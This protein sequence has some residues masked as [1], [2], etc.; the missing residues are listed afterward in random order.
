MQA[1]R[2]ESPKRVNDVRHW[3]KPPTGIVPSRSTT[4]NSE[5]LENEFVKVVEIGIE[6][7]K[8]ETKISEHMINTLTQDP[9]KG[10]SEKDAETYPS[11]PPL[12]E[13]VASSKNENSNTSEAKIID[14]LYPP[15]PPID[16]S[17]PPIVPSAPPMH[18]ELNEQ[19]LQEAIPVAT[20][21]EQQ[22][23]N[24]DVTSPASQ[25]SNIGGGRRAADSYFKQSITSIPIKR[26]ALGNFK[27]QRALLKIN[28]I[29]KNDK[30]A[31]IISF[32]K[33]DSA[34]SAVTFLPKQRNESDKNDLISILSKPT[35]ESLLHFDDQSLNLISQL[36][37][38]L[39]L[40]SDDLLISIIKRFFS[41]NRSDLFENVIE[42]VSDGSQK[43]NELDKKIKLRELLEQCRMNG[44]FSFEKF[45]EMNSLNEDERSRSSLIELVLHQHK[46]FN[47]PI[48]FN[49]ETVPS[50]LNQAI[51]KKWFE[52]MALLLNEDNV[53]N[54]IFYDGWRDSINAKFGQ[55][56]LCTIIENENLQ[57][58]LY[59]VG[60]VAQF[61]TESSFFS[62][63][64]LCKEIMSKCIEKNSIQINE[65]LEPYLKQLDQCKIRPAF[66]VRRAEDL[67]YYSKSEHLLEYVMNQTKVLDSLLVKSIEKKSQ[68]SAEILIQYGANPFRLIANEGGETAK[69][70][71]AY[72]ELDDE[73]F[74]F[75]INQSRPEDFERPV[76]RDENCEQSIVDYIV[77]IENGDKRREQ[78]NLLL[79]KANN[80][81][82]KLTDVLT[83][84]LI[85]LVGSKVTNRIDKIELLL[86]FGASM[87]EMSLKN[88]S[89]YISFK[90]FKYTFEL[91]HDKSRQKPYF[92]RGRLKRVQEKPDDVFSAVGKAIQTNDLDV[93]NLFL[94][95]DPNIFN[96]DSVFRLK[97]DTY[98]PD[99]PYFHTDGYGR[100]LLSYGPKVQMI[101]G[102]TNRECQNLIINHAENKKERDS[103]EDDIRLKKFEVQM[104]HDYQFDYLQINIYKPE[105]VGVTCNQM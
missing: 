7:Q 53:Q 19:P 30:L 54:C 45:Y 68:T 50:V 18:K 90:A 78:L 32:Y 1:T 9:K 75:L 12:P 17:A 22:G 88:M 28:K 29:S 73:M 82:F 59:I 36:Y 24:G 83:R 105:R 80:D 37:S 100:K 79:N 81:G 48:I 13:S 6:A 10:S 97:L 85:S 15:A 4:T 41:D 8:A 104:T 99:F 98:Y 21:V 103:V 101:N 63:E 70:A 39:D 14:T 102:P 35:D 96:Y 74:D 47:L 52:V 92:L 94:I 57:Q 76:Y 56:V 67:Y 87:T 77:N 86:T 72:T 91:T 11:L 20:I 23:K 71:I 69:A 3:P 93:L 58:F 33:P 25:T 61:E 5:A 95:K 66:E 65:C 84:S 51:E 2:P 49:K 46:T 44:T 26:K 16:S 89:L 31:A 64:G 55:N 43:I 40:D 27:N 60:K 34:T 62:N 42:N 38:Y